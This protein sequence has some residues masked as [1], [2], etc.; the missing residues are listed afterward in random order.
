[1]TT[2]L[3]IEHPVADF[4]RWRQA[5]DSDPVGRER[6]G[7]RRYR[8][9]RGHEDPAYVLIDLEFA[10]AQPAYDFPEEL[11]SLWGRVHVISD[12]HARVVDLVEESALGV[13]EQRRSMH[14]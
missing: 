4:N 5:F 12:P 7:V 1:M 14:R 11:Q 13:D 6:H 3:R 10:E 9:L 2:L 8:I